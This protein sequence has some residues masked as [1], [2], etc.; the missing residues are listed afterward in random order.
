MHIL[1]R[2]NSPN[3]YPTKRIQCHNDFVGHNLLYVRDAGSRSNS[4]KKTTKAVR[5][6]W[7]KS[8]RSRSDLT[9][10]GTVEPGRRGRACGF[11]I[12]IILLHQCAFAIWSKQRSSLSCWSQGLTF[13]SDV[14]SDSATRMGDKKRKMSPTEGLSCIKRWTLCSGQRRGFSI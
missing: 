4:S 6:R 5:S 8:Q 7:G 3:K 2:S 12:S 14:T 11:L 9:S 10:H 1:F 13:R